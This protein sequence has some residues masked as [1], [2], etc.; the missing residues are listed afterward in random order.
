MVTAG[1]KHCLAILSA[2]LRARG[3]AAVAVEAY[4]LPVHR[5]VVAGMGLALAPLPVLL[6]GLLLLTGSR[7]G[8]LAIP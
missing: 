7:C 5:G 1:F 8:A 6:I 4:G 2:A 3:T